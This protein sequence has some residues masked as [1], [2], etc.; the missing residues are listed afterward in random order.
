M[1][2]WSLTWNLGPGHEGAFLAEYGA[3]PDAERMAFYRLLYDLAS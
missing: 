3:E 1:A 2:T